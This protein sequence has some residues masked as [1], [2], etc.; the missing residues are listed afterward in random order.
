MTRL[1]HGDDC[2]FSG[3]A[4]QG[5]DQNLIRLGNVEPDI[6]DVVGN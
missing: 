2:T 3:K 5:A 4:F 1:L 6:G